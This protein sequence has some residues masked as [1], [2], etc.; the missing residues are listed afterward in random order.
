[1]KFKLYELIL[2]SLTVIFL[3]SWILTGIKCNLYASFAF[4]ISLL[5]Y[6][7]FGK[8]KKWKNS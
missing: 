7:V 4:V 5:L 1:M 8:E 3:W 6:V 2:L